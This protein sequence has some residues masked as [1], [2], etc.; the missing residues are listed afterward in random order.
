M[1]RDDAYATVEV[2]AAWSAWTPLATAN[3]RHVTQPGVYMMRDGRDG[4][5]VYVGL[6]GERSG[7]GLRG[8][9]DKYRGLS[10]GFGEAVLAQALADPGFL[11]VR[12]EEA[13]AGQPLDIREWM[14]EAV[15]RAEVEV[16]WAIASDGATAERLED[17]VLGL[18][19]QHGLWNRRGPRRAAPDGPSLGG[20]TT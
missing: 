9:L 18:L 17:E 10:S 15:R 4:A 13:L 20:P 3:Y 5:I 19:R 6:A 8:R 14:R 16:R 1:D 12:L 2:L 11:R 7:N